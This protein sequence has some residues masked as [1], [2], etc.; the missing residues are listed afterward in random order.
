[1]D[2][3]AGSVVVGLVEKNSGSHKIDKEW[4][5]VRRLCQTLTLNPIPISPVQNNDSVH[6]NSAMNNGSNAICD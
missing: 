5:Y 3:S 2:P 4:F 6:E 1:M